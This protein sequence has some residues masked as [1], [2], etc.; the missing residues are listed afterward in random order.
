[1][2]KVHTN[3]D[4]ATRLVQHA[5]D[6]FDTQTIRFMKDRTDI[7]VN[8]T[9]TKETRAGKLVHRFDSAFPRGAANDVP[10]QYRFKQYEETSFSRIVN[11]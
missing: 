5:S 1:M 8:K 9:R 7:L 10:A 4:G 6:W 3:A 2:Q 11:T